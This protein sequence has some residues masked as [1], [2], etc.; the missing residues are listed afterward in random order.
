VNAKEKKRLESE[1]MDTPNSDE[2]QNSVEGYEIE[3]DIFQ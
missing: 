1:N 2:N 3:D